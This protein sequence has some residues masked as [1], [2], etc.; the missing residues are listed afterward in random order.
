[1]KKIFTI[2]DRADQRVH[3]WNARRIEEEVAACP[4]RAIAKYLLDYLPKDAPILEAGCG[5]GAWVVYLSERGYDVSGVDDDLHLIEALIGT[6]LG[7]MFDGHQV[8]RRVN[9][10]NPV[11]ASRV[12]EANLGVP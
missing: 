5:L 12:V 9:S 10:A 4:D 8:S 7:G 11:L 2:R 6:H 3:M 1:M